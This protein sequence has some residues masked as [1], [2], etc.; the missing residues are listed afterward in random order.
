[1]NAPKTNEIN[2]MKT[3]S[4]PTGVRRTAYFVGRR[5]AFVCPDCAADDAPKPVLRANRKQILT[6]YLWR[7]THEKPAYCDNCG[8]PINVQ[9]GHRADSSTVL[10]STHAKTTPEGQRFQAGVRRSKAVHP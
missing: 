7:V 3:E 8:V 4:Q 10:W 5:R 6:R 1:M 9:R 2:N